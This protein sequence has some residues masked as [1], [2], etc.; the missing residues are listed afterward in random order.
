MLQHAAT[1]CNTLHN[2]LLISRHSVTYSCNTLQHAATCCNT[3]QHAATHCIIFSW[4]PDILS[5]PA[6]THC[7]R[8]NMLQHTATCCNMLQHAATCCNTLHNLLVISRHSVIY[9]CKTL[10]K[11]QHTTTCLDF[12]GT[13]QHTAKAATHCNMLQHTTTCCA[14]HCIISS[15][16]PDILPCPKIH[17]DTDLTTTLI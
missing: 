4:Y 11:L 10:Q 14:T 15:W 3:L 17:Y 8:C 13:L 7:K 6:A 5:Y 1:C 9:S 2:L 12:K 16:Y